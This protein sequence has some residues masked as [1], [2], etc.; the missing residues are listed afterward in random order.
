MNINSKITL[1][2]LKSLEK[3]T[4]G[5]L[6]FG[7]LI[8]AIRQSEEMS[9]V[10]FAEKLAISKQQLCDLE[11]GRKTVS[12]RLA[13]RYAEKLGYSKEQ[14]IRLCLQ[15][16][17]DRAGLELTVDVKPARHKHATQDAVHG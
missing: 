5:P 8:W 17:V 2:T 15:D 13:E 16:M 9:Q 14:F 3:I 10:D 7:K 12:P 1:N 6:T 4:G 11:H